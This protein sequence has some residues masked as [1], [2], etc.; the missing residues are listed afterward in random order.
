MIC[1]SRPLPTSN[2]SCRR[3]AHSKGRDFAGSCFFP[4]YIVVLLD[5]EG[6]FGLKGNLLLKNLQVV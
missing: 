4:G 1:R 5:T 2:G 3:Q 6:S